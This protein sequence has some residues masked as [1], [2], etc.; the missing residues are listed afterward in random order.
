LDANDIIT[1][2][3]LIGLLLITLSFVM[4]KRKA[5]LMLRALFSTRYLQQLFREGKLANESIYLYSILLYL[6]AFPCLIIIFFQ[7]YPATL[8]EKYSITPWLLY[9]GTFAALMATL[10]LSRLL[11]QYFTSIFNYQE[12]RYLYT[13]IKGLYRF[14]NALL[15]VIII[16]IAWYSHTPQLIFFVYIPVFIIIFSLFFIRFVRNIN[17]VSRIHFFIYFCSLEILP[18][19]IIAKLL[20]INY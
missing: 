12:Q 2:N 11:L 7:F 9:V 8:I 20:I 13:T 15:L 4:Y 16:P 17:G 6:F 14:Y 18:Y 10:S 19:L 1:L 3:V 5:L